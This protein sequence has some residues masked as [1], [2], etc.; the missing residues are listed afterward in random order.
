MNIPKPDEA[1]NPADPTQ[2][3]LK[4]P[5]TAALLAWLIPG[6]GHLYQGRL[7]KAVLFFVCIMGT[8][9]YGLY[10]G[11]DSEVGWGRVVYCTWRPEDRRLHYLCQ[12]GVGLPAM[13]ALI[14]TIRVNCDKEPLGSFMAPPPL[15]NKFGEHTPTVNDIHRRLGRYF[16]LG[17]L[18]T[19]VAGLLNILVILDALAGPA[20]AANRDEKETSEK[21]EIA[22]DSSDEKSN[23]KP[24]A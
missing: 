13:P 22:G 1:N 12:I 17:E 10:L 3:R 15:I 21:G 9:T 8:F 2:V 20:L 14:Q 5:I 16:S 11:S 6:L 4:D 18:Y 7:A 24:T 23:A 19:S